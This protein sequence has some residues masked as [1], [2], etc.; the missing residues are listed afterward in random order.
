M[1]IAAVADNG[2]DEQNHRVRKSRDQEAGDKIGCAK[3]LKKK[4]HDARNGAVA[5]RPRH[6]SPEEPDGKRGE[7]EAGVGEGSYLP[8]ST[9]G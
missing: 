7:S 5:Q 3:L 6:V 9:S 1:P 8:L 2:A 4:L